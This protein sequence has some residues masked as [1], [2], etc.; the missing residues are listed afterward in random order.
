LDDLPPFLLPVFPWSAAV[1]D[2]PPNFGAALEQTREPAA[3][4]GQAA[5]RT[6][7]V[8]FVAAIIIQVIATLI[9]SE[10]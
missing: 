10:Y 5:D 9:G 3:A 7:L 2:Q 1:P 8:I 4:V 6:T